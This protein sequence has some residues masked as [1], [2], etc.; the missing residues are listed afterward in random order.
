MQELLLQK[1]NE[2][3]KVLISQKVVYPDKKNLFKRAKECYDVT[4]KEYS[5]H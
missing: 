1:V 4:E 3:K 2:T 5:F